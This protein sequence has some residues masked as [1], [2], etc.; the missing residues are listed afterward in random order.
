MFLQTSS[1]D[2][3]Q[4]RERSEKFKNLITE[5]KTDDILV[6]DIAKKTSTMHSNLKKKFDFQDRKYKEADQHAK[7]HDY[8][9]ALA[10]L[11]KTDSHILPENFFESAKE[12]LPQRKTNEFSQERRDQ[13]FTRVNTNIAATLANADTLNKCLSRMKKNRSPGVDG[14][15]VEHLISTFYSGNGPKYLK[16]QI[17]REYVILL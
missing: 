4:L 11:Q 9:K 3:N 16:D 14:L 12:S 7:V 17:V 13:L 6:G 2:K 8:G 10:A 1:F 5:E 15:S